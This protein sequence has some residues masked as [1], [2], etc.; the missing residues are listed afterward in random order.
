MFIEFPITTYLVPNI[1]ILWF[2]LVNKLD[3]LPQKMFC[4]N[5]NYNDG[6]YSV[7]TISEENVFS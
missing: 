5:L 3:L 7:N 1:V 2:V 6:A 4:N